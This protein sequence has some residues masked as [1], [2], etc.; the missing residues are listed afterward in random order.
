MSML[1]KLKRQ[2]LERENTFWHQKVGRVGSSPQYQYTD[3]DE[4]PATLSGALYPEVT[5]GDISLAALR[6]MAF[7]GKAWPLIEGTA[8]VYGM[9]VITSMKQ[10]WAE[11]FSD[12][13]AK[14]IEFTLS[15]KKAGDDI[16]SPAGD[17]AERTEEMVSGYAGK[18]PTAGTLI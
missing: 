17:Y 10:T 14:K 12:G 1:N 3:P 15:L 2:Q 9:F 18:L 16:L 7:S 6:A 13:K 8:T 5:D 4:E 11:F